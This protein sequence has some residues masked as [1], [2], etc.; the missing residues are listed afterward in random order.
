[1]QIPNSKRVYPMPT[2]NSPAVVIGPAIN[3]A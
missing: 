1:M 3:L 2:R